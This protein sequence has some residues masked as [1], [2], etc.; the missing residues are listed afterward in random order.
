M[1]NRG[2]RRD[3]AP[4]QA[5]NPWK[6]ARGERYT[7]TMTGGGDAKKPIEGRGAER[8]LAACRLPAAMERARRR[9]I[10]IAR[11]VSRAAVLLIVPIAAYTHHL[12][13]AD[14]WL[15]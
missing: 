12:M 2:A 1:H 10:L 3:F 9:N 4:F 5:T 14:I 13:M 11:D 15:A 8:A 6:A 7:E